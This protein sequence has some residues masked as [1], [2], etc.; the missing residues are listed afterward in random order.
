M[1]EEFSFR[2]EEKGCNISAEIECSNFF[3][4]MLINGDIEYLLDIFKRTIS[5]VS[6][7]Q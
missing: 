7:N 1:V 4:E 3:N 6:K 5:M 2:I